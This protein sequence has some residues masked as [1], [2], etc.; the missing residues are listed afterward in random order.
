MKKQ[1]KKNN[2]MLMI[3]EKL[4]TAYLIFSDR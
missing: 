4:T 1:I 2:N 3:S